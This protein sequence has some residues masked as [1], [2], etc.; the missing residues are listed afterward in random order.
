VLGIIA[1]TIGFFATHSVASGWV[2][3]L[4]ADNKGHASS[5]YLLA[6]Y[7]G[8]SLAGSAGG[9]FW[10]RGGWNG[11]VA[12]TLVLLALALA[13]SFRIRSVTQT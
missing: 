1:L 9:W 12:F 7:V 6:Y 8:A 10:T 3:R 13:A 5:L 2:G 4:A 11:V